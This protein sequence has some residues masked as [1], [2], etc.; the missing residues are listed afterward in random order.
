MNNRILIY[1]GILSI[2]GIM[3]YSCEHDLPVAIE[4]SE[5]CFENEVLPIFQNSCGISNCHDAAT[6]EDDLIYVDYNTIMASISPGN[7][8]DSKAY[9]AIISLF[10]HPMPPAAPLSQ[11]ARTLI[12]I[13][14]DQGAKNTSCINDSI[15]QIVYDTSACFSRDILP[16]LMSSCGISNC[17][18]ETSHEDDI[19]LTNYNFVMTSDDE[20]VIPYSASNSEMIEVL[21]ET[22]DDLMP[23]PPYLPLTNAQIAKIKEWIN[24]GATNDECQSLCDT[25][26]F[27]FS[28]AIA[29]IIENNCKGCH[30]GASP[31]AEINLTNYNQVKSIADDGSLIEVLNTKPLMPPSGLTQCEIHQIEKWVESGSQNN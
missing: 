11:E 18:D 1:L 22:G 7:A 9:Q 29:G 26:V 17:H 20:L 6:A 16:I 3:L 19:I 10:E 4:M 14:I 5:I 31:S 2:S 23:P 8:F 25:S 13:W 21:T 15:V 30:S 12:Q 28:D 27:T 24:N